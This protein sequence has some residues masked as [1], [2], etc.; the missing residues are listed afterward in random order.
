LK[1]EVMEGRARMA[2]EA[3]RARTQ[4]EE[5][6]RQ[7]HEEYE[8]IRAEIRAL[9]VKGEERI[10]GAREEVMRVQAEK[11]I[12]LTLIDVLYES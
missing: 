5:S 10:N 3:E 9:G 12:H 8:E 4:R 6:L 7:M 1:Q 11:E 2:A